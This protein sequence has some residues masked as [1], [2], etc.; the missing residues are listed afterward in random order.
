M[1]ILEENL[2]WILE[3]A[4]DAMII[5]GQDGNI[6]FANSRMATLFGYTREELLGQSV[7]SLLPERFRQRHQAQRKGYASHSRPRALGSGYEFYGQRKDGTEFPVDVS[8]SPLKTEQ[9]ALVM[10]MIH[11]ITE[12]KRAAELELLRQREQEFRSLAE[13][14]PDAIARYDRECRVRYMNAHLLASLGVTADFAAREL[15]G[16]TPSER[17]PDGSF[18]AYEVAL[19]LTVESG[20]EKECEVVLPDTGDGV[21]YHLIRMVPERNVHGEVVGLLAIGRD[22]TD[23]RRVEELLRKREAEFR[24]LAE[25]SPDPIFRY[26]P[27]GRRLYLSP[28]VESMSGKSRESLLEHTPCDAQLVS[29]ADAE[30]M[31]N[32]IRR[33]VETGQPA[34]TE[35]AFV[36]PDGRA[37]H[38]HNRY[39]PEWSPDG[40]IAS[41]L[42]FSRDV[43]ER[44]RAEDRLAEAYDS[45]REM[46][47]YLETVREEEQKRIARELHDEMGGVLA[48]LNMNVARLE[49]RLP[50][51]LPHLR[52]EVGSMAALVVAA[53]QTMRHTVAKLRPSILD[54]VGLATAIEHYVQEFQHHTGIECTL[55]N[56]LYQEETTLSR[57]RSATVFRI[58]QESLTN[59]AKHAQANKVT[60]VLTEMSE[61]LVLM[62]KDNGKGFDPNV[63]GEES[64]GLRGIRERAFMVG[65]KVKIRSALGKGTTVRVSVPMNPPASAQKARAIG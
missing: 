36:A 34:E 14:A 45:L 28:A 27:D 12:R 57:D 61:S 7:E 38:F 6:L 44:K 21:R 41:V 37:R 56:A 3:S 60:I 9:G 63:R 24:T 10:A 50:A 54:D 49:A 30:K 35:V 53:I 25:N 15:M 58:L 26:A 33:V 17:Y 11:D 29:S 23:R 52:T 48:A 1:T 16:R 65:G 18:D 8:L 31:L 39:A 5:A 59:V 62:V 55:L 19:K 2:L 22:I 64:F 42:C 40:K 13:N 20:L 46:A 43:T 47:H 32:C 51:E 4:S